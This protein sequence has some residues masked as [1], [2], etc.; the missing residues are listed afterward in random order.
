MKI[1]HKALMPVFLMFS[2]LALAQGGASSCGELQ[3]N[4]QQYQACATT[5]QFTNSINNPSQENF[6][7][8]CIGDNLQGPTWFFIKIKSAGDIHMQISQVGNSGNETDVDFV[9]W[10]PFPNLDNVCGQLNPSH[11]IDCSWSVF[12][13]EQVSLPNAIAGQLY[14]LLV[15]NYSNVPGEITITQTGGTGSSDCGFLSAVDIL[16]NTGA[17]ITNLNYCK[18]GTKDLVAK[19]DTSDFPG[20]LANYRYNYKWYK[21]DVLINTITDSTSDTNTITVN[22]TGDY[23]VDMTAYDSTDPTVDL[24]NLDISSDEITLSF[25]DAPDITLQ[26]SGGSCLAQN[27]VLHAV[28][29]NGNF[30]GTYQWFRNNVMIPGAAAPDYTPDTAGNYYVKVAN[31]GCPPVNSNSI[32]VYVAPQISISG[33]QTICEGTTHTITSAISN[34][35]SLTSV[36]FRWFKDGQ[37]IPGATNNSYIVSAVNQA[38]GTTASYELEATENGTC[39]SLTNATSITIS[40]KPQLVSNVNLEQCDYIAPNNDGI[41]KTNL[42]QVYQAITNNNPAFTL[43]YYLDSGLTQQIPDPSAFT[44]TTPNQ[45]IYVTGTIPTSVCISNT[46]TISLTVS[47]TNVASYT[48]MAPVCPEINSSFGFLDF[49]SQRQVIKNTFFPTSNVTIDFYDNENDAALEQNPLTNTTQRPIGPTVVYARIEMG[50]NCFEVGTFNTE[51]YSAP[52]QSAIGNVAKCQSDTL[53]L[54]SK[55]PEALAGQNNAVQVSYFYSFDNAKNNANAI[56]K[57]SAV[58]LPLGNNPIFARL[59]NSNSQCVSITDFT[60][61]VFA[62]PVLTQPD[63]ISLCGDTTAV[64]NLDSRIPQITSGNT[65]YQVTFFASQQDLN[66]GNAIPDSAA[67]E[68]APKTIFIKAI[69]PTNNG[70]PSTTS[71][72]LNVYQSPGSPDNPDIIEEC[73]SD[74]FAEFDLTSHEQQMAGTTPINE[75]EFRYYIDPADA[76]ANNSNVISNPGAFTNTAISEQA[77]Y[78]RL[79]GSNRIDSETGIACYRILQQMIYARPFPENKLNDYP[80]KICLDIDGNV[81]NPAIVDAGLLHGDYDFI[82]YNGSDAIAGNEIITS[83]GSIFTTEHEGDYS[84]RITDLTH[85]TLCQTIVNFTARNSLIPFSLTGNPT[86]LVAFETDNTITAV[87]TPPSDDFEYS[88]DNTPWQ[89]SNVFTDVKEGIYTLSVRNKYGCGELSTMVVVTDY[90]RFFT[91]NGDGYNDRWNI[92]G[93]LALDK[94]NVFIYDRFG[95]LMTEITANETGWDG[96]YNGKPMPADDYWFRINYI[97]GGQ[98]KEFLGHFSLKR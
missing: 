3:A 87:V 85:L 46:A 6:N 43:T 24:T 7:T 59:V 27:P 60:V 35:A 93:R 30:D 20:N 47:P 18:P 9:L 84:V 49:E 71:L 76:A 66:S 42:T 16:D 75:I 64:F 96:T 68:S 94:S 34:S 53:L 81:V 83:N 31:A 14:V 65:N 58:N 8:S 52:L 92:G 79:N 33:N 36:T 25:F 63:D 44:N 91:P 41:A 54:S 11:E 13:T 32:T 62:N 23:R 61:T 67:Y 10:G 55:D 22:E 40:P 12:A 17:E 88:L 89:D 26:L 15:D 95:K 82:W 2:A 90:P 29:N 56:P 98:K 69:D 1:L 5:I 21:D 39:V 97:V 70:C 72:T 28:D 73:S 48:N 78:V 4:F 74:G 38:P 45:T 19:V 57:T 50:N 86:E 80:Y 51:I 77:I 37:V